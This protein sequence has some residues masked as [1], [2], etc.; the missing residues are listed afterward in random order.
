MKLYSNCRG[1]LFIPKDEDLGYIAMEAMLS[2]K[3]VLTTNDSGGPLEFI[4]DGINGRIVNPDVDSLATG[5]EELW[6]SPALQRQ[7]GIEGARI[8]KQKNITWDAVIE[9]LLH[10]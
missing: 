4:S 8:Y 3:P 2:E 10:Q 1:V 5:M 6:N 9:R 7:W